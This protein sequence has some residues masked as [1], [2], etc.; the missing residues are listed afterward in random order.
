MTK[1]P[2]QRKRSNIDTIGVMPRHTCGGG[3]KSRRAAAQKTSAKARET[4]V[5]ITLSKAPWE[6]EKTQ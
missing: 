4:T 2:K 5:P 3:P 6:Q 1:K